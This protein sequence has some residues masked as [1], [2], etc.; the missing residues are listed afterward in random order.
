MIRF[1]SL[2]PALAVFSLVGPSAAC[3]PP[4]MQRQAPMQGYQMMQPMYAPAQQYAAPPGYMLVPIPQQPRPMTYAP[5]QYGGQA[6]ILAQPRA[7]YGAMASARGAY[8]AG[9]AAVSVNV[10]RALLPARRSTQV[11]VAGP[12]AAVSVRTGGRMSAGPTRA[13]GGCAT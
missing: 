12:G 13:S 8:S 5:A 2:L 9:G 1:F 7:G 3:D 11:N 6:M 4:A 10:Q